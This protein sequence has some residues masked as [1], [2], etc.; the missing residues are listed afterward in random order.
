VVQ[1]KEHVVQDLMM[2]VLMKLQCVLSM[3]IASVLHT[4]LV[5]LNVVLDLVEEGEVMVVHLDVVLWHVV[6]EVEATGV[7]VV[8][9]G[10]K[11]QLLKN[12]LR[13]IRMNTN[14]NN[15]AQLESDWSI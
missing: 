11:E 4:N 6:V 9:G 12:L 1:D 15:F 13:N 3:D 8:A 10:K 2:G 14:N 7:E 5:D